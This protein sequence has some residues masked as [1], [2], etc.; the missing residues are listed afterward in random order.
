MRGTGA[1][2]FVVAK[3]SGNVGG[4]KGPDLL[5]K[6]LGQPETGGAGV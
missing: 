3:K 6:D 5:A 2:G 4:A 1:D